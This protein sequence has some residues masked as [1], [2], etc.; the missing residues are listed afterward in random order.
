MRDA[1]KKSYKITKSNWNWITRCSI[2]REQKTIIHSFRVHRS[3]FLSLI[4]YF[5]EPLFLA[6]VF[7][8]SPTDDNQHSY[9]F[10]EYSPV[11]ISRIP[12]RLTDGRTD[13]CADEGDAKCAGRGCVP[14]CEFSRVESSAQCPAGRSA[15]PIRGGPFRSGN[16]H[17]PT[18]P[19]RRRETLK[20]A[21][22]APRLHEY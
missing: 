10:S 4:T 22:A 20:P 13:G 14:G 8:K 7:L 17:K 18:W 6:Y 16:S 9:A 15:W 3:I 2:Q 19:A 1:R 11:A 12:R 5:S 21:A